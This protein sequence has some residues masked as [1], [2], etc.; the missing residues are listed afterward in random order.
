MLM[1][2]VAHKQ[3]RIGSPPPQVIDYGPMWLRYK[4]GDVKALALHACDR[5]FNAEAAEAQL[6]HL[7]RC[8]LQ[9][10]QMG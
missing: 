8:W 5:T 2:Q 7:S 3:S 6:Q 1:R 9:V 4:P 10:T